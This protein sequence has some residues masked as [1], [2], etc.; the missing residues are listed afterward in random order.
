MAPSR[1]HSPPTGAATA[2][3]GFGNHNSLKLTLAGDPAGTVRKWTSTTEE[4]PQ[5]EWDQFFIHIMF[6]YTH[7]YIYIHTH[8]RM[9]MCMYVYVY[10]C[11]AM[12]CSVVQ[13]NVM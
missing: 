10:V 6:V 3:S 7:L 13:C 2:K 5:T 9:Y 11:N 12:Q 4:N 8:V 1:F